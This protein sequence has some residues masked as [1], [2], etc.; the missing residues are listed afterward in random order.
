MGMTV[1]VTWFLPPARSSSPASI[2]ALAF[3]CL[4]FG[5]FGDELG[6]R[7]HGQP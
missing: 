5:D 6:D 3:T 7:R 2:A 4:V 1:I